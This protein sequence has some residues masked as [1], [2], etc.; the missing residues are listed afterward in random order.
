[1][2]MIDKDAVLNMID[3]N[4]EPHTHGAWDSGYNVALSEIKEKIKQ[5]PTVEAQPAKNGMKLIDRDEVGAKIQ[6][7]CVRREID[8]GGENEF[9]RGM[10]KALRIVENAP[11]IEV[12][13]DNDWISVK[14]D[15]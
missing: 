13:T 1:M 10:R 15:N 2:H 8:Y 12:R 14:E 7:M 11:A 9:C 5:M 3:S 6:V 4:I